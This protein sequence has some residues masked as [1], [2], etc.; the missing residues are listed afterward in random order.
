MQISTEGS[1]VLEIQHDWANK[2]KFVG[3]VE[4]EG[5]LFYSSL[6]E[7]KRDMLNKVR[8]ETAKLGG[9]TFAVTALVVERGL[10]LPFAQ[11]DSYKC[12]AN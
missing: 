9:N 12:P 10:S 8:N 7:A 3:I 6:P 11:A 1:Q 2:S 5:G 4:A